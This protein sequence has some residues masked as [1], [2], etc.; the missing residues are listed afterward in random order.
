MQ[1]LKEPFSVVVPVKK[2]ANLLRDS[3]PACYRLNP[4]EIVVCF[5]KPAPK[6]CLQVV[7]KTSSK[8]PE[9]RTKILEVERNPEYRFHQAWVRRQGFRETK[10][11]RV[12]TADVDLIVN[13]NVLKAIELVGRN[14]IGLVSCS[15]LPSVSG[16]LGFWRTTGDQLVRWF[17]QI[18]HFTGLY[19]IWKPY[20]LDSEDE[21]I[22]ELENPRNALGAYVFVGEDTFLLNCM[23]RKHRVIFLPDIGA[24]CM[25]PN[26][27][28]L[29][30]IQFE[31]GRFL[32]TRGR[33]F[34]RI[35]IQSVLTAR[36]EQ[37]QGYL[38]EKQSRHSIPLVD[39]ISFPYLDVGSQ[40]PAGR[41]IYEILRDRIKASLSLRVP[42][43]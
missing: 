17:I 39:P 37:V 33:R 29:S 6:E 21:R 13:A 20:W 27:E 7:D 12:L 35:L 4:D 1:G 9:I 14:D 26:M 15:K 31:S 16:L 19:C 30:H 42:R 3:L 11:N 38:Y 2:E 24:Y 41:T 18:P 23:R 32:Q 40:A 8:H 22:K 25:T 10:N 43:A 36:M 28:D 5:D 34:H